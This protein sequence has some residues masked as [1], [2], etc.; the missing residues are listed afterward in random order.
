MRK[1]SYCEFTN[2]HALIYFRYNKKKKHLPL[3]P[4]SSTFVCKLWWN[5]IKYSLITIFKSNDT[6]KLFKLEKL[7]L[8]KKLFVL[9][10]VC[11]FYKTKILFQQK[12]KSYCSFYYLDPNLILDNYA[13]N[14]DTLKLYF[15]LR[16]GQN[17]IQYF[18]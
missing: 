17:Q 13:K 2:Q 3:L 14:F 10:L 8:F 7:C 12:K 15:K 16:S 1:K 18:N 6:V 11:F 4:S 9:Q 5:T